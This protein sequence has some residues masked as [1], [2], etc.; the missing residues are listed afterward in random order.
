MS[1]QLIQFEE[2]T[3][4]QVFTEK[5]GLDPYIKEIKKEAKKHVFDPK[6][7]T[8]RQKTASFSRKIG[9]IINK[10]DNLGKDSNSERREIINVVNA[11]RNRMK[12]ILREVQ[13]DVRKPLD[14]WEE[15]DAERIRIE[16]EK[17]E[18]EKLAIQVENDHEFAFLLN[19]QHDQEIAEAL[20]KE[21]DAEAERQ[22]LA[23]IA[24]QERD[25]QIAKEAKAQAEKEKLEA[26]SKAKQAELDKIAIQEKAERDAK[27]AKERDKQ[28]KINAA[29][30]EKQRLADVKQAKED[31]TQR[32][33]ERQAK[34]K[35]EE[36]KAQE[37]I[38]RNKRH[39][40]KIRKEAKLDLMEILGVEE[41]LAVSIV[42]AITKK[43]ISNLSINY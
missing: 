17:L 3:V 19:K 21:R 31:A 11:E 39:I 27:V 40:G 1:D 10:L 15:E 9:T 23:N 24:Q 14:K 37:K 8:T 12:E 32:E 30:A 41:K 25:D 43:L 33:I 6:N 29:N 22:R 42:M 28:A 4:L 35:E 26:E 38:E 18:A 20:Q 5:N 34:I 2:K 36:K 13:S 7:A 16:Q